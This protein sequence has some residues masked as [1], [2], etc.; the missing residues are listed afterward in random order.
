M[1]SLS[2]SNTHSLL[3]SLGSPHAGATWSGPRKVQG[4]ED[5]SGAL[6]SGSEGAKMSQ[7]RREWGYACSKG[8][9]LGALLALLL[10]TRS[11]LVATGIY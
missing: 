2:R 11:F 5:G 6:R 9:P 10:G 3:P 8:A 7:L 1:L 4:H